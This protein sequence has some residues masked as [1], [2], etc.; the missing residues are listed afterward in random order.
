MKN[1]FL[2]QEVYQ[3]EEHLLIQNEI[4]INRQATWILLVIGLGV[5]PFVFLL[6]YLGFFIFYI[7]D[8]IVPL[9]ISAIALLVPALFGLFK[10]FNKP[11]FKY[12]IVIAVT[13]CIPSVY[14]EFDYMMLMLWIMPILTSCLYFNKRLNYISL[15]LTIIVL[16][17]TSYYRSYQRLIDGLINARIGGLFKDFLVSF[18]TYTLITCIL[19]IFIR[20]ITKKANDL[21]YEMINAKQ[22]EK[23]SIVDGLTGIFNY[24]Y[25]M[26]ALEKNK[27]EFER[28]GTPFTIIMFDVDFFKQIN[29]THGHLVGDQ[30]LIHI[31][32]FL[33][34]NIREKDIVGRYGGE[35]FIIIFPSTKVEMAY[36][37]AERCR[38]AIKSIS[39]E[40]TNIQLSVSGGIQEYTGESIPE[41]IKEA[42]QKMY[43]A[44]NAGRNRV[45]PQ[46]KQNL[47]TV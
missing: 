32:S 5:I 18:T 29:D 10:S 46:Y 23:M 12:I 37:I 35:E 28:N 45:E 47:Q 27:L 19:F 17:V 30:A 4:A 3:Q 7:E 16:G 11:W 8:G 39:I 41:L 2:I 34:E 9:T 40:N 31:C 15:F 14:L 21:L 13:L 26:T 36:I 1:E 38:K 24:R 44:K 33:K 25:I 43:F 6:Q 42:D 22:F 20:S